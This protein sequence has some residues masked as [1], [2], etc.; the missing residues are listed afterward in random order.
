MQLAVMRRENFKPR[1]V[2]VRRVEFCCN[3]LICKASCPK[4]LDFLKHCLFLYK[5]CTD[6]NTEHDAISTISDAGGIARPHLQFILLNYLPL[7]GQVIFLEFS[8]RPSKVSVTERMVKQTCRK[9]KDAWLVEAI[10]GTLF[11]EVES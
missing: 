2:F 3:L 11:V 4:F 1:H 10:L 9:P 8:G 6:I 5:P 7:R